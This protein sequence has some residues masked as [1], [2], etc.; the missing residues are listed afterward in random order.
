[1]EENVGTKW[2]EPH[3]GDPKSVAKLAVMSATQAAAGGKVELMTKIM[4]DQHVQV[5]WT[6]EP[7]RMVAAA[8]IRACSEESVAEL[9]KTKVVPVAE[10]LELAERMQKTGNGDKSKRGSIL[11][12]LVDAQKTTM[13]SIAEKNGPSA[14]DIRPQKTDR[15]AGHANRKNSQRNRL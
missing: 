13:S 12:M 2:G 5:D 8:A 10:M 11:T 14:K 6:G 9:I 3:E 15:N 7:G 1:M 4:T